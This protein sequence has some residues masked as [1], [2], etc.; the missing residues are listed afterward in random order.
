[1]PGLFRGHESWRDSRTPLWTHVSRCKACLETHKPMQNKNEHK[2]KPHRN[3]TKQNCNALPACSSTLYHNLFCAHA[4]SF[5]ANFVSMHVR[6]SV[7]TISHQNTNL[8]EALTRL[9]TSKC[10]FCERVVQH[11]VT[12][13]LKD[14]HATCPS[15]RL[16]VSEEA[17]A[18]ALSVLSFSVMLR[19]KA[20]SLAFVFGSTAPA[21]MRCEHARFIV[22]RMRKPGSCTLVCTCAH[23]LTF[24][25]VGGDQVKG[26]R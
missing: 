16:E 18:K 9:L 22:T 13:W 4:L 5:A 6:P 11:C 20:P 12:E 21:Q 19:A 3:K 10:I 1:M 23:N 8:T 25:L 15:C 24:L 26:P 2:P 14:H 17:I 7:L